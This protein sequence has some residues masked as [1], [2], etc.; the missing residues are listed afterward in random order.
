M[1]GKW[2]S[3]GTPVSSTNKT[4]HHNIAEIWLK[5]VLSTMQQFKPTIFIGGECSGRGSWIYTL[6]FIGGDL[7]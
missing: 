1:A 3:P 5:V 2:F 4:D 7:F 6:F